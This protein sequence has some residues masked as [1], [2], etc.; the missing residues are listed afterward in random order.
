MTSPAHG[1]EQ[2]LAFIAK[3]EQQFAE[4]RLAITEYFSYRKAQRDKHYAEIEALKK[5]RLAAVNWHEKNDLTAKI[6]EKELYN[7]EQYLPEFTNTAAPYFASFSIEDHDAAIGRQHYLLGKQSLFQGHK[8]VILDWRQAAVSSLYYEYEAG[9]EYDEEINGKDR[10][11]ILTEK[12]KYTC[13]AGNLV[14]IE[15]SVAGIFQKNDSAGWHRHGTTLSTSQIKTDKS[16]HHLVDIVS[17]IT[18][19]QFRLITK[20]YHGCLRLLGSAGAGKTTIALHRLSFLL[21]NYPQKF[22]PERCLILMFNRALRD[23]VA[24]T[25]REL[26][27]TETPVETFH[28]WT[29][30]VFSGLGMRKITFSTSAPA[31]FD[32]IKKSNGMARLLKEYAANA[33]EA[34]AVEHL[35]RMFSSRMLAEKFLSAEADPALLKRFTAYYQKQ[36][37]ATERDASIGFADAGLLL[38]LVQLRMLRKNPATVNLALHYFDHIVIDEAQDLSQIELECLLDAASKE[39]SLTICSDANQRILQSIGASGLESFELHLEKSGVTAENLQVSYR[40]TAEI[41][42]VANAIIGVEVKQTTRQGEPVVFYQ[43]G[44]MDEALIFLEKVIVSEQERSPNALI[45]VICKFKNE[46]TQ[47]YQKLRR[48][49][50]IRKETQKFQPGVL[51]INAHQVKG[52]EF[53]TVIAWNVSS[54]A[55]RANSETDKNLLYVVASRACD[56]LFVCTH[57]TPSPY[58]ERFFSNNK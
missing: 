46:T 22:R 54:L 23:Y 21:Y 5:E 39:R 19:A 6:R 4:V 36:L 30:R 7:P 57:E 17:L 2:S 14:R 20:E 3:E 34:V 51:I 55:Y 15:S 56:R 9:E 38:R 37:H 49:P 53:T 8:I 18:P 24:T 50:G 43:C 27:S 13:K 41:M 32:A 42:E 47:L 10:S 31:E 40:S 28:A 58:L 48:L 12:T 44:L 26:V 16:D 33:D 1:I 35:L 25:V 52:L 45:A 11:G 29:A